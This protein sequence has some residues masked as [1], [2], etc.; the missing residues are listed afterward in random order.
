MDQCHEFLCDRLHNSPVLVPVVNRANAAFLVVLHPV[1]GVAPE[2]KTGDRGAVG[3][4]QIVWGFAF[5]AK[6]LADRTHRLVETSDR[7]AVGARKHYPCWIHLLQQR[8]RGGWK[9]HT[10]AFP[11][12]LVPGQTQFRDRLAWQRPPTVLHML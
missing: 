3:P 5:D 7:V 12:F 8:L 9:P 10:M 2:A 6:V 1:H 11:I 4:A